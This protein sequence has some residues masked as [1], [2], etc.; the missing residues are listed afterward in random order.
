MDPEVALLALADMPHLGVSI[1]VFGEVVR[2]DLPALDAF[3]RGVE[4]RRQRLPMA[5]SVKGVSHLTV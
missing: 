2:E 4:A 5:L 1:E 3:A